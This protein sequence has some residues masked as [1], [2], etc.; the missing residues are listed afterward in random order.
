MISDKGQIAPHASLVPELIAASTRSHHQADLHR[1]I[2]TIL[3][4]RAQFGITRVGSLTR[5]DRVNLP[6][7]QV[8]RPLALSNA[9]NQGRGLTT[10]Q[11]GVSALMEALETWAAERVLDSANRRAAFDELLSVDPR[12]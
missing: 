4:R 8:V 5:L 10:V 9:V 7:V 11:A 1:L 12:T 6:V 2:E 3:S